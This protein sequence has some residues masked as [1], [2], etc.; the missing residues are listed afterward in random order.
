MTRKNQKKLDDLKQDIAS[1]RRIYKLLDGRF[2]TSIGWGE[3]KIVKAK[4]ARKEPGVIIVNQTPLDLREGNRKIALD[5]IFHKLTFE[6]L[7][8]VMPLTSGLRWSERE[9]QYFAA[10]IGSLYKYEA[11][12]LGDPNSEIFGD[13]SGLKEGKLAVAVEYYNFS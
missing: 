6:E 13:R 11:Y 2:E 4:P 9:A 7:E 1:C 3:F 12:V 5:D 10:R 8:Y